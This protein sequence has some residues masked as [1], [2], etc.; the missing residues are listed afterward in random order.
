MLAKNSTFYFSNAIKARKAVNA[1]KVAYL[2]EEAVG[3]VK[4][5]CVGYKNDPY[6]V[7]KTHR[8]KRVVGVKKY[9]KIQKKSQKNRKKHTQKN[10]KIKEGPM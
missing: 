6:A 10:T 1:T 9:Q 5:T 2:V 8:D 4:N 3:E 7:G